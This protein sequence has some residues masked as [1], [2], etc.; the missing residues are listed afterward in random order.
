MPLAQLFRHTMSVM[1]LFVTLSSSALEVTFVNPGYS[2]DDTQENSTGNFWYKVAKLMHNSADDLDI[3]LNVKF[4]NR[5][6]ILMKELIRDAIKEQPDYLI[7]VDEKSVSS[8]YLTKIN[9]NNIPIFFLLN[10]PSPSKLVTLQEQGLNIAGSISPDNRNVGRALTN[11]L[12]EEHY[13]DSDEPVHMLAL[14]GDYTTPASIERTIGLMDYLSYSDITLIAKDVANW[15]EQESYIKTMAFLQ[16]A[17]EINVI[18]CAND[19]IAFGSKRALKKLKREANVKV[20]GI[21]WDAT[22]NNIKPLDVSFGGHVLLGAYA[23]ITLYDHNKNAENWPIAHQNYPIFTRLTED[24]KA[25]V[26]LINKSSLDNV[27]FKN[28]SKTSENWRA[29]TINNL[30]KELEK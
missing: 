7:L 5:N 4:A 28:F 26:S 6:H 12:F 24:N 25:L 11:A 20:G 17:P 10:P 19:A 16:L 3:K 15:S 21:N 13:R 9:T 30:I 23:L 1:C 18:W 27:N 8:E 29:F 2:E 14:L 22:P